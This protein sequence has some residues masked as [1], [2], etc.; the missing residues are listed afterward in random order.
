MSREGLI[1]TVV[2]VRSLEFE[3]MGESSLG[4]GWWRASGGDGG[5]LGGR[6]KQTKGGTAGQCEL[7]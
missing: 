2:T 7:L 6:Q 1:R 3:L 5:H 4:G